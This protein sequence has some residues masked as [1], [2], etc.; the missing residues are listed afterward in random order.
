MLAP[1][2]DKGKQ[3]DRSEG[4]RKK[5][6]EETKQQKRKAENAGTNRPGDDEARPRVFSPR[7]SDWLGPHLG[8]CQ[9]CPAPIGA[10]KIGLAIAANCSKT[11]QLLANKRAPGAEPHPHVAGSNHMGLLG[12]ASPYSK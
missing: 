10:L 8:R 3:S 1:A 5:T 6:I 2:A 7:R 4:C 9:A 12:N 11:L